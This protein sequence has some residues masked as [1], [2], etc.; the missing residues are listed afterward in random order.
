[1]KSIFYPGVCLML[2]ALPVHSQL[3]WDTNGT[4]DGS[5]NAGGT[6][7]GVANWNTDS[8]GGAG[9]TVQNWV[10][11]NQAV[12][13]A[14]TDG[15]GTFTVA[16]TGTVS[17]SGI[18]VEEGSVTTSGGTLTI[19][20]TTL[21]VAT[22]STLTLGS[23]Y[24]GTGGFTKTGNGTLVLNP[25]SAATYT[26]DIIVSGGT[27]A[28]SGTVG[29]GS[30]K[31]NVTVATGATLRLDAGDRI[32]NNALI[33]VDAGATFNRN[34]NGDAIGGLAGGGAITGAGTLTL[35]LVGG[36]TNTFS[37][38]ITG[39]GIN[40]RGENVNGTAA[41][42]VFTGTATGLGVIN[43]SRGNSA[44][45]NVVVEFGGAGSTAAS[46]LNLGVSGAGSATM[47]I[48]GTHTVTLGFVSGGE[49]NGHPGTLTQSGGSLAVTGQFRFGHWP[50]ETSTY[51]LSSGTLSLPGTD[52][53]EEG[54]GTLALG[55]D[56]TGI[57]NLSGGTATIHRMQLDARTA[58]T[59]VDQFN[60]T[61]GN[62]EVRAGGI[63]GNTDTTTYA[64]NLGGGTIKAL[65]AFAM[66]TPATLTG[67][68]GA[69]T[70]NSNG[71]TITASGILSGVGGLIKNGAGTLALTAQ[72]TYT[73]N[74]T[75]NAG[76]LQVN[77]GR[78]YSNNN[79]VNRQ[80]TVTGGGI[81]ESGGW[82]DG[83][84]T[85][86]GQVAFAA[87]NILV[88]G[89]TI[90]YTGATTTGNADRG[91]TIGASGAILEA[92]GTNNF[93]L[94]QGR[95]FGAASAS[96]GTLTLRGTKNGVWNMNLGGT[97]GLRKE[98]TGTWTVTNSNTFTGQLQMAGGTLTLSGTGSVTGTNYIG[99]TTASTTSVLNVQGTANLSTAG[100]GGYMVFGD[101]ANAAITINQSGGTVTNLGTV[102]LPGGNNVSNR[103]GHWGGGTTVY[104]L[105]AGTLN[106]KGA[107]LYL[108]WD[109]TANLNITGGTA[110]IQGFNMGYGA[111]GNA[112]TITVGGTGRLNVGSDG[113]ITDGTANKTI[114]L[115]GGTL[116]AFAN[117]SS[118]RP[119]NVT[120]TSVINTLD[121]VDGT[122]GRTITLTGVLSGVGGITKNGAGTLSLGGDN[123]FTGPLVVNNGSV[124]LT[125]RLGST[126]AI[127]VNA[128]ASL[129]VGGTN[130][131]TTGHGSAEDMSITLDGGTLTNTGGAVNRINNVTLNNGAT[132]TLSTASS[133]WGTYFLG[134]NSSNVD[135]V[136]TAGGTSASI[137]GGNGNLKM[138]AV[139][140]F[141]VSDATGNSN[142]DLTIDV[143]LENQTNAQSFAAASLSKTGNGTL[144]LNAANTYSGT[145][146]VTSG[147]LEIG[148]TNGSIVTSSGLVINGGTLLVG[149]TASDRIGNS[150]PVTFGSATGNS[151]T[152]S[153]NVVETVGIL[154]VQGDSV[155]DFAAGSGIWNF[156]D[157][158]GATAWTG[159]L[160]VWNWSGNLVVG[161]GTDQLFFG[162]N[163]SSLTLD[164]ISR[165]E[166][167]SG[168]G[169]GSLGAGTLLSNGELV[170]VPEPSALLAGGGLL[171]LAFVRERR[172]AK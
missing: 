6:W 147:V 17:V 149:G 144:K 137:I 72:E 38:T 78:I 170:P 159:V 113:I 122:T 73:G 51:N 40:V 132:W 63:N 79:W 165:I 1:M 75:V 150:A 39:G 41:K 162:S 53:T 30:V 81:I 96:A 64:V 43:V 101:Q 58:T 57:F 36:A 102:N 13:S 7:D 106:L 140:T 59:G 21:Q 32:V 167:F 120:T 5:G 146:T 127:T 12:F 94:D 142:P 91:F 42:Q 139:T 90:R 71:F 9:G 153:G 133:D 93:T 92:E 160:K 45:D 88:N 55:I 24:A 136:V 143:P 97:G 25:T 8:T 27:L 172:R 50:N 29:D 117:W 67:T 20:G 56:G 118:S 107:P 69:T 145:T 157:S 31:G 89:G 44:D 49:A 163:A 129:N 66:G 105:S 16:I 83:D 103:W 4:T 37:G 82:A 112:S 14:G 48:S 135:A 46:G 3:Y 15:I 166:F 95:G 161:G 111:R 123:T 155:L 61:G 33:T 119:M 84:T 126:T 128:G 68:N 22:G 28:V 77:T 164:Q 60:M 19:G 158:S 10:D 115:S 54:S 110:N 52:N 154:N 86:L 116:G 62:L 100:T 85:G 138:S 18:V 124:L 151:L 47:L 87:G 2:M 131:F 130:Y 171:L 156:A 104:N 148:G 70:F 109:G 114:N 134:P 99:N 80:I 141:S 168:S 34:G 65:A 35:D 169:T 26:G 125:N 23:V 76:T 152:L 121:S 11:G 98:G 74:T 108:S